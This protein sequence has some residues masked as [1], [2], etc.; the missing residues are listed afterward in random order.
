MAENLFMLKIMATIVPQNNI[1]I[2][3]LIERRTK[4]KPKTKTI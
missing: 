1:L 4:T 2:V 3:W